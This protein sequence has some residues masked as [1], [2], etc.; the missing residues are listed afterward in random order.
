MIK[1]T[2]REV[3]QAKGFDNASALA[4]ATGIHP[5]SMYRIWNGKATRID[6]DTLDKLCNTL[7]VPAG[8]LITHV[9]ISDS[10]AKSSGRRKSR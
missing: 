5:T 9:A 6:L 8:L 10:G 2:V 3:A 1:L 4:P 7:Q